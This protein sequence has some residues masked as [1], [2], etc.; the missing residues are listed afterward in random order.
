MTILKKYCFVSGCRYANT[1][2]TSYHLCGVTGCNQTGHGRTEHYFQNKITDLKKM[3]SNDTL[4][5]YLWCCRKDC[6]TYMT[7]TTETHRCDICNGFHCKDNCPMN[8][9]YHN[10]VRKEQLDSTT[11]MLKIPDYIICCP[12][13]KTENKLFK[14]QK[15]VYG[16]DQE[17]VVCM[18][19]KINVYLPQCGHTI[20]CMNCMEH[21]SNEKTNIVS[22]SSNIIYE[23]KSGLPRGYIY[24]ELEELIYNSIKGIDGKIYVIVYAGMGCVWILRREGIGHVFDVRFSHSDNVIYNSL[25]YMD[26][27]FYRGYKYV[28]VL[29]NQN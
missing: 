13:C 9:E 12:M 17:C 16:I 10:R 1:H 24:Q 29:S 21:I 5:D 4:P 23:L 11:N 20:M 3:F 7:H 28:S 19:N 27:D 26:S 2:T 15:P 6:D 25:E 8:N 22:D 18:S 14:D